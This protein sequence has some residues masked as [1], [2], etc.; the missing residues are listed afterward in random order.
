MCWVFQSVDPNRLKNALH[1]I[2][3]DQ[4]DMES[5]QLIIKDAQSRRIEQTRDTFERIVTLFPTSGRFWKIYI[6]Q[7]MRARNY[8][9][10]EK[11]RERKRP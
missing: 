6:E 5:W 8:D 3:A 11:V 1:K 7:E 9:K 4:W 10:V 2:Q